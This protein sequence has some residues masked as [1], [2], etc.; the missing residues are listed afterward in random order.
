[1]RSL[2][3]TVRKE[4]ISWTDLLALVGTQLNPGHISTPD[5]AARFKKW[6]DFTLLP[7]VDTITKYFDYSVWVGG[8]TPEGFSLD[9]FSPTP[10]ALR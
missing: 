2:V 10:P 6:A 3:E 5:D 9:Y 7:P 4:Q 1:M 8:F